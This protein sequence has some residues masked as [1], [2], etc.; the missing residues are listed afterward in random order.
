MLKRV[1]ILLSFCLLVACGSDPEVK[2]FDA[3]LDQ[4]SELQTHLRAAH[5]IYE[6]S[7]GKS[8]LNRA[9]TIKSKIM[10]QYEKYLE[11]LQKIQSDNALVKKINAEGIEKTDRS[12]KALKNYQKLLL[13]RSTHDVLKARREADESVD[14]LKKWMVKVKVHAKERGLSMPEDNVKK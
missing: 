1:L 6:D 3:Y 11:G 2:A 12:I 9:S 8:E 14:A 5:N 4:L 7:S 10:I 13:E